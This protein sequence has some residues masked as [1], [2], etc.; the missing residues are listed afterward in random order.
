MLEKIIAIVHQAGDMIRDAHHIER[1]TRE[2]TGAADLVTKY[3]VAVQEFLRRELLAICPEADFFGEEGQPEALTKDWTFIVD[4][5][6]GTT[7]FVREL[8]YSNIAVALCHQGQVRYAVVYNP[9]V[10]ELYAAERGHGATLNG[11]TIHVSDH[12]AAHAI[13]MC[14]STIYDRRYTDR[15]FAIMRWL[16]DHTLDFRR[17]GS[18]ELDICQVAAGRIEVFFECRLSPWDF[19]AG[20]LILEEA[21]GRLTRLDGSAIDPREPGSVWATND[22]CR[23]LYR[24][25]PQ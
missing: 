8:H 7:N 11:R 14:G 16:Y 6:D 4:P 5:I 15:S 1:D 23:A 22:K 21:G 10:E 2:K 25:L 17:F 3:D 9:F 20:S 24:E 12:D 18:A 13:C 19:A